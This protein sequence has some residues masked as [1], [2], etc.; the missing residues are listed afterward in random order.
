MGRSPVCPGPTPPW[1][2]GKRLVVA[3]VACLPASSILA[4][5]NGMPP[6]LGRYPKWVCTPLSLLKMGQHPPTAVQ[7][8]QALVVP[9]VSVGFRVLSGPVLSFDLHLRYPAAFSRPR[10]WSSLA[11]PCPPLACSMSPRSC[12]ILQSHCRDQAPPAPFAGD[13]TPGPVVPY[14]CG[15]SGLLP[16]PSPWAIVAY[17]GRPSPPP[18]PTGLPD[19]GQR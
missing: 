18:A 8:G 6:P 11:M 17:P 5:Q 2:I 9:A 19:P 3:A 15:P 13:A 4:V 7:N 16:P 12:S 1:S 10:D 14:L